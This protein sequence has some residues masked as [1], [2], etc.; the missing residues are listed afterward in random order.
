VHQGLRR[1]P[2]ATAAVAFAALGLWLAPTEAQGLCLYDRAAIL[3]G[4]V[5]RLWTCHLVHFSASHLGWN[6]LAATVAGA[7]IERSAFPGSGVFAL[8]APPCLGVALLAMDPQL[9]S[10]GGLSGLATAGFAFACAC[11]SR[12]ADGSRALW[13][14]ALLAIALKIGWEFLSGHAAFSRFA[15]TGVQDAPLSH[16]AGLALGL[17][18]ALFPS[19]IPD[20]GRR[21]ASAGPQFS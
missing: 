8:L 1:V 2:W 21:P 6:L 20:P 3:H 13:R 11:E 4:E 14:L 19:S 10:Y 18:A 17:L 12:R 16:L 5:W 9:G 15:G 7:W